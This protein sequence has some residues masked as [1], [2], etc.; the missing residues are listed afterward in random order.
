MKPDKMR[1]PLDP[2]DLEGL[3]LSCHRNG[4]LPKF[5]VKELQYFSDAERFR[6]WF[7]YGQQSN[8]VAVMLH[9]WKLDKLRNWMDD[10]MRANPEQVHL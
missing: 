3:L 8:S 5:P 2:S 9:T 4:R 7:R 1:Q 10:Q 6:W